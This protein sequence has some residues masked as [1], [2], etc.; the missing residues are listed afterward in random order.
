MKKFVGM[1]GLLAIVSATPAL[2]GGNGEALYTEKGCA[3]C[4]GAAGNS[5]SGMFPNL[6]GQHA[7]YIEVQFKAIR[8]GK[9]T[10][11]MSSMMVGAVAGVSDA[12]ASAIA[13]YLAAQ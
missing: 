13:D 8:D 4:H 3:A 11:G 5:A 1:L 10:S 7:K 2:A 12:E 9:R 6:N